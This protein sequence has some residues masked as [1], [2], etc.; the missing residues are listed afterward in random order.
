M[1]ALDLTAEFTT[2]NLNGSTILITG[3]ASGLGEALFRRYASCGANVIIGDVNTALGES[4]V[5]DVRRATNNPHHHFVHCD[6]S[7]WASQRAMYD[8]AIAH[9]VTG[10]LNTV[11]ANAGITDHA[12]V[13]ALPPT[14]SDIFEEPNLRTIDVNFKGVVFTVRLAQHHFRR[15]PAGADMHVVLMGSMASFLDG[16][17]EMGMYGAS[18]HAVLGYFRSLRLAPGS[19]VPAAIRY[20]LI[21]PYFV[22]TP[23]TPVLAKLL[24]AG[25]ELAEKDDVVESVLRVQCTDARGA[26]LVVVPPS[27]GRVVQM[28]RLDTK[29]VEEFTNRILKVMKAEKRVKVA[30]RAVADVVKVA[31]LGSVLVG[32][33]AGIVVGIWVWR[34]VRP[35]M[36][37]SRMMG[38]A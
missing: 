24:L 29:E 12:S 4:I 13:T 26:V 25:I 6:V 38:V 9:S 11:I 20:N 30:V 32:I 3:G 34:V 33:L 15:S 27:A 28:E 23:I 2:E 8:F 35:M 36:V 22:D 14:V 1:A 16:S 17:G 31:G 7:S 5:A 18:K 19:Q 10:T 21:C 37:L